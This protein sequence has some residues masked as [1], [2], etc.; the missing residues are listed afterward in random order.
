MDIRKEVNTFLEA[1]ENGHTT[2]LHYDTHEHSS[3][4]QVHSTNCLPE[5]AWRDLMLVTS[6]HT[7]TLQNN[8]KKS[9]PN[10]GVAGSKPRAEINKI[11]TNQQTKYKE[12]MKERIGL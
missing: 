7:R 6:Q 3:T 11:E 2:H 1:S 9:H 12:S 8:K 5:K 10:R 4:R